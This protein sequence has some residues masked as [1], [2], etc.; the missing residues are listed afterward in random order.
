MAKRKD[1]SGGCSF[2]GQAG[3][4]MVADE[5]M[6]ICRACLRAAGVL[7]AKGAKTTREGALE[8]RP[9]DASSKKPGCSFCEEPEADLAIVVS[10]PKTG[11]RICGGCVFVFSGALQ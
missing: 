3:A 4:E 7:T 1:A 5:R 10:A 11:A 8:S 6:R 9:A 2:C